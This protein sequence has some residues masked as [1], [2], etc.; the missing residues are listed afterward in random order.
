M[1]V[2]GKV[3]SLDHFS[4]SGSTNTYIH[5]TDNFLKQLCCQ[6]VLYS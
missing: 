1:C 6:S 4:K 3:V 2:C 5:V